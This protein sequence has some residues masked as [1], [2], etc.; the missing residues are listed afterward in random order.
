MKKFF[1][2]ILIGSC[3]GFLKD[4]TLGLALEVGLDEAFSQ[5]FIFGYGM[6]IG[7]ACVVGTYFDEIFGYS[8]NSD[9]IT[10]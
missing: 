4:P 6:F 3:G 7:M 10:N 1:V 8:N 5:S 9:E 2:S